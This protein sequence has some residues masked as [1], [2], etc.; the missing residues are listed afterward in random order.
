M[1]FWD[2]FDYTDE[3]MLYTPFFKPKMDT[4]FNKVLYPNYDSV[5][6]YVYAFLD[7]IEE[8]KRIFQFATSHFLNAS[9]NSNILGMDALF[10]DIANDYYFSGKAFWATEESMEKIRENV[11][12]FKDNLIGNTAPDLTMETFDGEY[13]NLHQIEA[14]LTLLLIYEPNCSHCKVFIPELYKDVFLPN[15]EKGL[16]VFAIYSMSDKEE[17][18]EFLTKHDMFQWHNVWDPNHTTRFKVKYDGRKTPG[19]YVLDKD[20]TIL[21]KK[22]DINQLK[23]IVQKEM[24]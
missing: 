21:S 5:K 6:T 4:W 22:L 15:K 8:E 18:T 12:F 14:N 1:H 3:R 11:L 2:Y 9:I 13:L 24:N 17:W 20:K 10:I 16:E 23:Q 19:I 7:E